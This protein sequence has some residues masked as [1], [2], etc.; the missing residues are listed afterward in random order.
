MF[1]VNH[2]NQGIKS[3]LDGLKAKE[4]ESIMKECLL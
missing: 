4:L 2:T 1:K 3:L